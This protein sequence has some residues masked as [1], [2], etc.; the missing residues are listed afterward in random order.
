MKVDEKT[1]WPRGLPPHLGQIGSF[2][3][4]KEEKEKGSLA[5]LP[6]TAFFDVFLPLFYGSPQASLRREDRGN[7][8]PTLNGSRPKWENGTVYL[9]AI[10]AILYYYLI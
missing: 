1:F 7:E 9:R 3:E 10:W 2:E 5:V 6:T 8:N 4:E